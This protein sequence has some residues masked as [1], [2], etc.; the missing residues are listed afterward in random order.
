[1]QKR[2]EITGVALLVAAAVEFTR[3]GYAQA[4]LDTITTRANVSK[5]ALYDHFRSKEELARAVIEAGS[6]RFAIA[7]SPFLTAQSPA[8][9]ALIGSSCL[10]LLDPDVNNVTVQ[11]TFRLITDIRD[12]PGANPTLLV[13]WLADYQQL[14]RRA[15]TEGD[16]RDDDPDAVALLLVETFVGVR[17]LAAVTGHSDDLPTRLTT[18]WDL[19]LPG[20][21]DPTKLDYFRR[22]VTRQV[23][24]LGDRR[25]APLR[26]RPERGVSPDPAVAASVVAGARPGAPQSNISRSARRIPLWSA[27]GG[28]PAT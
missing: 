14:T 26:R 4:R 13:T 23:T 12:H 24:P 11:A 2:A 5:G 17:L 19:L 8:F 18:V 21:V 28:S 7:R 27:A 1:M 3:V 10:L 20:L 9:E 25:T 16:L 15:V 22:F 6:A